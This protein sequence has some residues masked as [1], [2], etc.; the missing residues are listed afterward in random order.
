M[1][2]E[3]HT[4]EPQEQTEALATPKVDALGRAYATGKRKE[5]IARVWLTAGK[6]SITVNN[7]DMKEYFKRPNLQALVNLP[8]ASVD[9]LKDYTI[10]ATV[11]GG[12]VSG[13]AGAVKHAISKALTYFNPGFRKSLKPLGLLTRDSRIVESKKYGRRKARRSF[14]FSKR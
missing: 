6:G 3:I 10:V 2:N 8:L 12:G 4:Q 14:Q 11:V 1:D 9:G 7:V 13:Q 5:S